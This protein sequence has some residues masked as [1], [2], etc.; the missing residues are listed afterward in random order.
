MELGKLLIDGGI[1]FCIIVVPLIISSWVR[2]AFNSIKTK[3][4]TKQQL[5]KVFQFFE[6][7]NQ[8]ITDKD[9]FVDFYKQIHYIFDQQLKINLTREEFDA[10]SVEGIKQLNATG[11]QQLKQDVFEKAFED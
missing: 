7:Y 2:F 5:S 10:M 4:E 1:L 9:Q 3:K 8:T 6:Q 11:L